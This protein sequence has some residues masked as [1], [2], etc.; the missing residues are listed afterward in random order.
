MQKEPSRNHMK[1]LD[2]WIFREPGRCGKPLR[3]D[4]LRQ[5]V[6]HFKILIQKTSENML[7]AMEM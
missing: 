5:L 1:Q 7:P 6:Q 3:L 4:E 2:A